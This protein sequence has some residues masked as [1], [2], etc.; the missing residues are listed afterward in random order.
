MN[1]P[2]VVAWTKVRR[3]HETRFCVRL[4]FFCRCNMFV[5]TAVKIIFSAK[6]WV[7]ENFFVSLQG[8]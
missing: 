2:L 4:T 8:Q 7:I 3:M 6:E 5:W 1:S